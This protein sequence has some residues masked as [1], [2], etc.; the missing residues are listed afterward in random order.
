MRY[1][2]FLFDLDG[3]LVDTARYHYLAWKQLADELGIPFDETR[4]EAFKGV[5]RIR[6]MELLAQWGGLCVSDSEMKALAD[7]KNTWYVQMLSKLDSRALLPGAGHMLDRAA[8]WGVKCAICSASKNTPLIIEK[9]GISEVFSCVIDGNI[10]SKAKPDPEVFLLAVSGLGVNKNECV[11]FEDAQAGAE[12]GK[13]AGIFV[14]GVGIKEN[15]PSADMHIPDL[16]HLDVGELL[17][18]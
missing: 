7:R 17:A 1:K 5:S 18:L 6:C 13:S 12:A 4:N 14:V 16:A 10:T 2:A 8:D 11:I 9:L 15:I 3:V